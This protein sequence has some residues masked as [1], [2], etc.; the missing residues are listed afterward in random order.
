MCFERRA[1]YHHHINPLIPGNTLVK[2]AARY[3][4]TT[5]AMALTA[6]LKSAASLSPSTR[7]CR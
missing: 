4:T 7:V 6:D 1:Y 3:G 2:H 5:S